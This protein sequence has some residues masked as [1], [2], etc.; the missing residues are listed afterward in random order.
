MQYDLETATLNSMPC[1]SGVL[2][3]GFPVNLLSAHR[4]TTQSLGGSHP[5]WGSL[6][7]GGWEPVHKH[8]L[9]SLL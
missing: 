9:L 6:S 8:F 4:C 3:Q 1:A 2:P 7:N 5:M